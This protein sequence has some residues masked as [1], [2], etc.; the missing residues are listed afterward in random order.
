MSAFSPAE[1][2]ADYM[3]IHYDALFDYGLKLTHHDEDLTRDCL[4]DV[5][6]AFWHR[7]DE[8]TQI[9]SIR[10]YLL[11]SLR[12][13]IA[14]AQ[15]SQQRFVPLLTFPDADEAETAIVFSM[16]DDP[17]VDAGAQNHYLAQAFEQLPR[18]Q[19]EALF[20]RYYQELDYADVARVMGV[21]ERTVYNLVHE[22]LQ[23]LR[24]HLKPIRWLM[25]AGLSA[26]VLFLLKIF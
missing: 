14:D 15:R 10:G 9:Q 21:K 5:F 26:F 8:W 2:L 3:R 20:L 1:Q 23:Q 4:Q 18:R 17:A 24:Q 7:R 13:R 25:L 19:R 6:A 12:H 16:L 11:V 22:G